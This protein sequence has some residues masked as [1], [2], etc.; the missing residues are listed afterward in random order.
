[1]LAT[2]VFKKIWSA[3]N[4]FMCYANLVDETETTLQVDLF[5]EQINEAN[6]T[7]IKYIQT[8]VLSK[9]VYKYEFFSINKENPK[10]YNG[11]ITFKESENEIIN[12]I[13]IH[14]YK[15]II[16]KG[17]SRSSKT[18]STIQ[19][20]HLQALS[21]KALRISV[22]RETKKSCKDTVFED[23]QRAMPL[24]DGETP[25][26]NKTDTIYHYKNGSK[27]EFRGTDDHI[28]VHGYQGDIAHFNEPYKIPRDVFDQIDMRS[29]MYCIIDYNPLQGH[30]VEDI[31]KDERALLI[32]STYKDNKFCPPEQRRK[33]EKHQPLEMFS[34]VINDLITVSDCWNYDFKHNNLNFTNAELSEL[35]RCLDNE[36]SGSADKFNH[37]VY[38]LGE[39]AEKPNRI[40][41]W[42]EISY[43]DYLSVDKTPWIGVDWGKSDPFAIVEVKYHDGDLYVHQLNYN[44]ENY[45][46][47]SLL[48]PTELAQIQAKQSEGLVIWLFNKLGINKDHKIVCDNNRP[49]KVTALR[50]VGYENAVV[51]DKPPGSKRDGIDLLDKINVYYTSTS[52][53]LKYEQ[54]NYEYDTDKNGNRLEDPK[55]END[56]LM[57]AIRYVALKMRSLGIIKIV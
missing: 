35:A 14:R 29:N 57:D 23:F 19:T 12:N 27:I 18:H 28:T 49:T 5:Q 41:R 9:D 1:M 36:R 6:D 26:L 4:L 52:S 50:Q 42:K 46:K 3:T 11:C 51:A 33:I 39:K 48:K 38:A 10:I 47:N 8:E 20:H 53:D 54:E 21:K 37:L 45:I 16:L 32:H 43:Q 24:M 17:S 13:K 2:G 44:S 25:V 56:H 40:F 22:W 55:D 34:G 15:Y 31:A 30:W 7:E